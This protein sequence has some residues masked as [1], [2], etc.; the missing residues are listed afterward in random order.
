MVIVPIAAIL[1]LLARTAIDRW[2]LFVLDPR[3]GAAT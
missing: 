2:H 1:T 3:F